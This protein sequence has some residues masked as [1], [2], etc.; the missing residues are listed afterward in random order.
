MKNRQKNALATIITSFVLT[1]FFLPESSATLSGKKIGL[2][3]GHGAGINQGVYI[4][5][6]DWVLDGAFRA[7]THLKNDGASVVMTRT[8]GSNPSLST[9]YNLLN[10]N[11]VHLAISIH[12]NAASAAAV[13]M[14]AFYCSLNPYPSSSKNLANKLRLRSLSMVHNKD[15]G[16]KECL[17]AGH[18]YHFA[19]VRYT[20]MPSSLPEYYFHTNDW[21]NY[22]IH[23][24]SGG[25]E[26]VGKS[27][28]AGVCDYYG[29]TPVYGSTVVTVDNAH[30]GFSASGNWGVATWASDKYGADYAYR[31]TAAVSDAA[32]WTGNLPSSGTYRV[33]AWWT[34]ASNR[35]TSAPYIVDHSGGSSVVNRD[36]TVNGGK[37]NSLGSY[38]FGAGNRTTRLS[39]WTS[40]GDVV[41]ADAVRWVKQ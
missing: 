12:S 37:W 5:E 7:R 28:Y 11:N 9:R 13:G 29:Q 39:C 2:D 1:A 32:T 16:T 23:Y 27:L 40:S 38:S 3:P 31:S 41:I 19:M 34:A 4:A 36:Q 18:G 15:R 26:N 35:A 22:N 6:G 33:D 8:D 30:G 20:N 17:D 14:E 10:S 24:K 21:E 25:R